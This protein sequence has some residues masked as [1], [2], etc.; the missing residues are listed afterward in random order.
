MNV[1]GCVPV[2][3]LK[4]PV[5]RLT[6][7]GCPLVGPGWVSLGLVSPFPPSGLASASV[8]CSAPHLGWHFFPLIFQPW[9]AFSHHA[10]SLLQV[11]ETDSHLAHLP[12]S[13]G[14][15]LSCHLLKEPPRSPDFTHP[16]AYTTHLWFIV[17]EVHTASWNVMSVLKTIIPAQ[18][19]RTRSKGSV[20]ICIFWTW[21]TA[22]ETALSSV[23]NCW[24]SRC[25]D[26]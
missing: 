23:N 11:L 3:L 12:I 9:E 6:G 24:V 22:W 13:W 15:L 21:T 14:Q 18:Y 5:I 20:Y 4:T 10:I 25:V 8:L 19:V 26:E 1:C 17:S 2:K 7:P 16:M